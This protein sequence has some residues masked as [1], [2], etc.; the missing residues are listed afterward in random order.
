MSK[1]SDRE[2]LTEVAYADDAGLQA[3]VSLYDHQQ[4]R[5]DLV[6]EALAMLGPVREQRVA[7][8]G[9]GNG[10]YVRSL[11]ESGAVVLACDLSAGM[12]ASLAP[13]QRAVVADAQHLPLVDQSVDAVLL[14][15]MLYHVPDPRLAVREARRALRPGGRLL[16]STNSSRHLVELREVWRQ[17]VDEVGARGDPEDLDLTNDRF[18]PEEARSVL[19]EV[20]DTVTERTLRSA[21]V[22]A[23]PE[24]LLRHAA[25]TTAARETAGPHPELLD[26]L[27][28]SV[29]NAIARD[30]EFRVTT[31]PVVFLAS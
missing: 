26:R 8:V 23:D 21:V 2:Y 16:V 19:R 24:P 11:G 25:S 10:R 13:R 30:G 4:P 5:V 18:R 17:L 14:M 28:A 7:D 20:F 9:C 31:E 27:R 1:R 6:A 15:H 29:A 12:L 3:R 22:V